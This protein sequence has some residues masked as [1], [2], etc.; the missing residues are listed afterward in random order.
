VGEAITPAPG[1]N[2]VKLDAMKK[3]VLIFISAI[4]LVVII[5]LL[6]GDSAEYHLRE[7]HNI[8]TNSNNF[9]PSIL[10]RLNGLTENSSKFDYHL[11]KLEELGVVKHQHLVFTNV[12]YTQESAKRIWHLAYSQF[13]NALHY[14]AKYFDTNSPSYGVVPYEL[15]VWDAPAEMERWAMFFQT[16]NQIAK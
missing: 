4:L 10:D 15:E 14:S 12:P 9:Q 13:P 7:F 11:S 5:R 3:P 1:H 6:I 2:S 16:N 8:S